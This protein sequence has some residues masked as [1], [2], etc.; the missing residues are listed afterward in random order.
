[1]G[2]YILING[3]VNQRLTELTI[4]YSFNKQINIFP[5]DTSVATATAPSLRSERITQ[6]IWLTSFAQIPPSAELRICSDRYIKFQTYPCEKLLNANIIS[7]SDGTN[8]N[9]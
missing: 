7:E 5:H 9:L 1:M 3:E 2:Q 8:I 4:N 6:H